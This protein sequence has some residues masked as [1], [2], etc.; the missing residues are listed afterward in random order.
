MVDAPLIPN[1]ETKPVTFY[2]QNLQEYSFG[3]VLT[4][5]ASF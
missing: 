5:F 2:K 3:N 4:Y 1:F